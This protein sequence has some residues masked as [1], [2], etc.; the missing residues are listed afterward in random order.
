MDFSS[1][2]FICKKLP[3]EFDAAI[4]FLEKRQCET[5]FD[6]NR[7]VGFNYEDFF[8][9]FRKET[10]SG[11]NQIK[12]EGNVF[13]IINSYGEKFKQQQTPSMLFGGG[14]SKLQWALMFLIMVSLSLTILFTLYKFKILS[15][16]SGLLTITFIFL[17]VIYNILELI[18][19]LKKEAKEQISRVMQKSQDQYTTDLEIIENLVKISTEEI[20]FA[21]KTYE[22]IYK[23]YKY[24]YEVMTIKGF[25]SVVTFGAI[26]HFYGFEKEFPFL[27]ILWPGVLI[28]LG[29]ILVFSLISSIM[30]FSL[31]LKGGQ[32]QR[33][34]DILDQAATA[35]KAKQS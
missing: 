30:N 25:F 10:A 2:N 21:K 6:W 12:Y 5:V 9:I 32:Y 26:N 27:N 11:N 28:I 14:F 31:R 33:V 1:K 29:S 16:Y 34:I 13:E 22:R 4:C 8:R 20:F 35:A 17:F 24:Q 7:I 3:L 19:G 15:R 23:D 18:I